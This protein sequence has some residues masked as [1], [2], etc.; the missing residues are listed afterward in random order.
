[1]SRKRGKRMQ[2][3]S[4]YNWVT[5]SD[6]YPKRARMQGESVDNFIKRKKDDKR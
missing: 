5:S 2:G 3:Q 1:M 6:T 4:V